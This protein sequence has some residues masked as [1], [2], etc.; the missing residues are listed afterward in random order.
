MPGFEWFGHG[1]KTPEGLGWQTSIDNNYLLLLMQYGRIG[2][3]LWIAVAASAMIYAWKTVWNAPDTPYRRVARAVMF[4]VFAV[5]MTQFSV[6]LFSTAAMLNWLFIGLAVG[7]AQGL[8]GQSG[9]PM[10][11]RKPTKKRSFTDESLR[12]SSAL[13]S[14]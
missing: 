14:N 7:L 6:A 12:S 2:L 5:A 11:R 4:S 10:K 1:N 3:T 8:A 9:K 13:P